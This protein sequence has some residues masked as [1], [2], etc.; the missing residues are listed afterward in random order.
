MEPFSL[1]F[2]ADGYKVNFTYDKGTIIAS[3]LP[4]A[5]SAILSETIL[6]IEDYYDALPPKLIPAPP[7]TN[8]ADASNHTV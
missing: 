7:E 1:D 5:L 8:Q 3:N 2:H 6:Q 4:P